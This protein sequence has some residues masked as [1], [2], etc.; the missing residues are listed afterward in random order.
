MTGRTSRS[1]S[2]SWVTRKID[3]SGIG[4]IARSA[5]SGYSPARSWSAARTRSRGTAKRTTGSPSGAAVGEGEPAARLVDRGVEGAAPRRT[6]GRSDRRG[7]ARSSP[8]SVWRC[9]FMPALWKSALLLGGLEEGQP[10]EQAGAVEDPLAAGIGLA[11]PFEEAD[12]RRRGVEILRQLVAVRRGDADHRRRLARHPQHPHLGRGL[13]VPLEEEPRQPAPD[14]RLERRLPARAAKA[15]STSATARERSLRWSHVFFLAV[16]AGAR[17]QRLAAARHLRDVDG[18]V[19][20]PGR[21][22]TRPI[23]VRWN[24]RF[25]KADIFLPRTRQFPGL[26]SGAGDC[27]GGRGG[28]RPRPGINARATPQK[29]SRL[30]AAHREA[31]L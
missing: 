23:P 8:P 13:R 12:P 24:S 31:F 26:L 6:R 16:G 20:L 1:S 15:F 10:F 19:L 25:V 18:R 4:L 27:S 22:G 30:K 17:P 3:V 2:V 21:S 28:A 29:K 7:G 9:V 11:G 14:R 5:C